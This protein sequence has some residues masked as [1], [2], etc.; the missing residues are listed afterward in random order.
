MRL[1]T[2]ITQRYEGI[3]YRYVGHEIMQTMVIVVVVKNN[4][5]NS[6]DRTHE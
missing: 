4:K 3:I 1:F 6:S 5:G 2:G